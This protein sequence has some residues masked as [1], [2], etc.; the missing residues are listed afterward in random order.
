MNQEL[1]EITALQAV[2]YIL[3]QEKQ[4]DWLMNETGLSPSD[5][6]QSA[7]SPEILAGVLD[8]L[9]AHEEML[10]DFCSA[11]NI[12]PAQPA[13]ARRFFPGAVLEY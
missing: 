4:R 9:L 11:Q 7:D 2:A 13:K 3:G 8:F 1:A 10:I 5:F 6:I 12:D